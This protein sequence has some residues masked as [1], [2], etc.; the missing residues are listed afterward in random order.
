MNIAVLMGRMT[1]TPELKTTPNGISVTSFSVAVDRGYG[2]NKQTDFI[3]IV[4]WRQTAEF[5]CKYFT[6]GSRIA[7]EGSIQTRKYQDREGN[8][9]IVFEVVANNV[10][11]VDGKKESKPS[12]D[13]DADPLKAFAEKN[14]DFVEVS[15]GDDLPF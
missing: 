5:I 4:A 9:R 6:K 11:F 14:S 3:N 1:S 10:H 7:I 8:N 12:V 2:E 15:G 13:V